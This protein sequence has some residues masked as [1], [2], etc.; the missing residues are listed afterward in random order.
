MQHITGISRYQM[1]FSSVEDAISLDNQVGF[2]EDFVES[3]D[4]IKLG[5]SV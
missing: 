3:I 2:I 4:L 1:R 5:F